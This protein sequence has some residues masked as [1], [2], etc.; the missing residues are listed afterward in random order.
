MIQRVS[1]LVAATGP[2]PSGGD[3]LRLVLFEGAVRAD[4]LFIPQSGATDRA[5]ERTHLLVDKNGIYER[6]C[7]IPPEQLASS[8]EML[9]RVGDD[10]AVA[11]ARHRQA[12]VAAS[13]LAA[14]EAHVLLLEAAERIF[15]LLRSPADAGRIGHKHRAAALASDDQRRIVATLGPWEDPTSACSQEGL[16][17][18]LSLLNELSERCR[19]V[20]LEV[21][22]KPAADGSFAP[23]LFAEPIRR[24]IPVILDLLIH[25]PVHAAYFSRGQWPGVLMGDRILLRAAVDLLYARERDD[26]E[27]QVDFPELYLSTGEKESLARCLR[28][29]GRCS[30][31]GLLDSQS[32]IFQ[33]FTKAG[34]A[35]SLRHSIPYPRKLESEVLAYLQREGTVVGARFG[36]RT[37]S[38]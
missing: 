35:A 4:F 27:G 38:T 20:G 19:S 30:S 31:K 10:L 1:P 28:P 23:G 34:R 8:T 22:L 25:A 14:F 6:V 5:G 37:R 9:K 29:L 13:A 36:L 11:L 3:I 16:A 21:S 12:V 17:P 7:R 18:V 2:R 32:E 26:L 33:V 24:S 15:A